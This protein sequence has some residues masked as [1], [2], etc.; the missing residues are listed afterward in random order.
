MKTGWLLLA[1][2]LAV[3]AALAVRLNACAFARISGIFTYV[4]K[5]GGRGMVASRSALARGHRAEAPPHRH[6]P[7]AHGDG[8]QY[9]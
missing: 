9:P 1:V 6:V 8:R 3:V 7:D 4:D 5:A 2:P